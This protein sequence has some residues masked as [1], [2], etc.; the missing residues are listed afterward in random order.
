VNQLQKLLG[1][2]IASS[3]VSAIVIVAQPAFAQ[4]AVTNIQ[5][6]RRDGGIELILET[7]T[8]KQPEAFRTTYG[9]TL[10]I[11]L[12]NTRLQGEG[13]IE[14]N[15]APSI[16]S[17]EVI[18]QYANTL[19]VKLVGTEEVPT[20]QINLT[21]RGFALNITT[22]MTAAEQP[23]VSEPPEEKP[24]EEPEEPIELVVPAVG[25]EY[26][27]DDATV[28]TRTDTPL[29]DVPQSIQVVPKAVAEDQQATDL[30][31]I[32][33]NV[34]G[35][36]QGNTFGNTADRFFIRG[37]EQRTFLQDGFRD[38]GQQEKVRETA[39]L[40]RVEVLK[41]PASVLYGT[42]QPGGIINVVREQP[43]REPSYLIESQLG[44]FN[45]FEP[46]I[47]FTGPINADGTLRYR[48]NL[49]S[50]NREVFRDFDQE[51]N[52]TF[53]APALTWE[54]G[55]RTELTFYFEY[56]NDERPFDRGI[57]AT[58]DGL[59]DIPFDRVLGE[60]DDFSETEEFTT[61]YQLEHR[62][63]ENWKIRN[64]FRH[65]SVDRSDVYTVLDSLDE[66]TGILERTWRD[67]EKFDETYALQTNVVGE[68]STG[69]VNHNLLFGIDLFRVTDTFEGRFDEG[70]FN[71]ADDPMAPS[72]N[73]F[74]PEYGQAPRPARDEL[75]QFEDS[76]SET[77]QLG[78]YLQNRIELGE[79]WQL[80]A[81]GRFD[82][83]EQE[84]R[85]SFDYIAFGEGSSSD[86]QQSDAFTPRIGVVYQPSET[87][88]LYSSFSQSFVPNEDL[89]PQGELLEPER[90]T[91]YEI[92]IKSEFLDGRMSASLAAFN[93]TKSNI[94][95][96]NPDPNG[97]G[98]VAIGEERSQ[99]IELDLRGEIL[100][101]WQVIASYAYTDVEIIE[102]DNPDF[103][104][105]RRENVPFNQASLWTTYQIP[106]GNLQGLGFGL[107]FF[108]VGERE[109]NLSNQ[110]EL[111]S[112]VRTDARISYQRANWKAAVNFKNLFD[113]DHIVSPNG[114]DKFGPGIPF[115][116]LGTIEYQF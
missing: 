14:Q 112:Y 83:V 78:I 35:V 62:F 34:S 91:Q 37:F 61:S 42:L 54:V 55:D 60:P 109:A 38:S 114:S 18:Q 24:T 2:G 20:A 52:R 80:L 74:D 65:N 10:I 111:S 33:R 23:L 116:V 59:A 105:N 97:R 96:S 45:A 88:S 25:G 81:G 67:I 40:E 92:G 39:N 76:F 98:S 66:E 113:V 71:P 56:L 90:G 82:I 69:S 94:A 53:I 46:S 12:I 31:E 30:R 84:S 44:D 16:A 79:K 72:I 29:R 4:T 21:D 110:F 27:V 22:E 101:G 19:R 95:I 5:V 108:F 32:T 15:P 47:D 93:I 11:D 58:D 8:D 68:F 64:N 102:D 13:F 1:L 36:I 57:I 104:G 75:P 9:E 17:I 115:T 6:Q 73:I 107:G 77:N 63:S 99:G 48:L 85:G 103:V 41:G 3:M 100:P 106:R 49:L 7:P 43:L 89:D 26:Q 50:E 70:A 28:G 87:L 86:E 51:I